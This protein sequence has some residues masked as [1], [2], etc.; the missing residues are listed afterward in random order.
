M[1][2]SFCFHIQGSKGTGGLPGSDGEPGDDVSN[3]LFL[4][5]MSLFRG[6]KHI[7]VPEV[8]FLG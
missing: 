5:H 3:T 8:L 2:L 7:S 4:M 6:N 1:S